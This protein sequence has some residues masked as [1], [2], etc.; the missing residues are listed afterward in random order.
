M[1]SFEGVAVAAFAAWLWSSGLSGEGC[2]HGCAHASTP[3]RRVPFRAG[4]ARERRVA[5]FCG[6]RLTV[7][8]HILVVVAT[9]RRAVLSAIDVIGKR[10]I[11][12]G[13]AE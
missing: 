12:T 9:M 2:R 1:I 11:N 7:L 3:D 8:L 10:H 6:P 5:G 13:K 4:A